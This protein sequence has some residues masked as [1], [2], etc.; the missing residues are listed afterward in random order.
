MRFKIHNRDKTPQVREIIGEGRSE[1]PTTEELNETKPNSPTGKHRIHLHILPQSVWASAVMII[2]LLVEIFFMM[3]MLRL[4]ILPGVYMAALAAV[5]IIID[6]VTFLLMSNRSRTGKRRMAG[7]IALIVMVNLLIVCSY[8]L[9]STYDTLQTISDE[10]SQTEQYHVIVLK[11][12]S[13]EDISQIEGKTVYVIA[14]KSKMYTEA[15]EK[16]LS[17]VKVEYKEEPDCTTVGERLVKA[18]GTASEGDAAAGP[19]ASTTTSTDEIIFIS[20]TNY[21]ML[22]EENENY[23]KQT[24][25]LFSIP[26]EIKSNDTAR[27]INVTEDPFNVYITGIDMW[28]DIDQVSRSDVNMIM[29]VN[30]QT[31]EILLT[32]MPRDS[33]VE[34]HS[35][36]AMDKLTHSGIYGVEETISTVEDWMGVEIN[37]YVRVNFSMLVDLVNAIGGID[38]ESDY[39]FKSK[40]S[41]YKYVKG[42][43]HLDGKGALY[44]ARER[45]AF[46]AQ[47]EQR[48]RNQQIVL[49]AMF[50]KIT[51]SKV[52]LSSYTKLLDAVEG[53]M[54]T[55][56]SDD[57]IYSL[58]KMQL[59]D[60][61]SW[62][63]KNVSVHGKGAYKTTY[64]M[65]N[66]ELF[67]SLPKEESVKAAAE[68]IHDVMYP[69]DSGH[70]KNDFLL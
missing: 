69:S 63:V 59:G 35:F 24:S 34:L 3:F 10:K 40:I 60:M 68:A 32:S 20:N 29:T 17:K 8:Y 44:F 6:V 50:K 14:N 11:D 52:L 54:Q 53:K 61:S 2:A 46:K 49:E 1:S 31:R 36:G 18:D 57:D 9:Y 12:G 38:V 48:I 42:M 41:K 64:S 23:K 22:C 19:D 30:P 7:G 70:D 67:V 47:D 21:E 33:Y 25:I 55:N 26:V 16:L 58:V 51:S 5:L 56:L 62:T 37:Y 13:Y 28:G 45:K 15:R 27:R 4:D 43:N 39:A 65:G 66:R